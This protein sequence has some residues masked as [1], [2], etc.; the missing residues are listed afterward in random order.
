MMD[1]IFKAGLLVLG[2]CFLI[3]YYFGSQNNRY[4]LKE[5][6]NSISVFDT[7]MGI[8]YATSSKAIGKSL[9]INPIEG[10]TEVKGK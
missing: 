4:I 7:R 2:V 6:E 1:K 8:I 10:K 3:L 9:V 5:G